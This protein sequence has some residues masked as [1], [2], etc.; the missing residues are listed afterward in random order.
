MK[1][2]FL[3]ILTIFIGFF[4]KREDFTLLLVTYGG[5]FAVYF[6]VM[7]F[8]LNDKGLF[9]KLI[10]LG[11]FL[12]ICLLFNIPNLSDD[13]Y[14]FLWDGRL[15]MQG[16]HPFLHQPAYF[17][18]HSL[19]AAGVTPDFVQKLNS[20]HYFTVYPPLCQ[21]LFSI[22]AWIFPTDEYW[23]V[24]LL[25]LFL[26]TC[27]IG[28]IYFL[29][30]VALK[31]LKNAPNAA[32]IYALNPLAIIEIVGNVHF[33]GAMLFF[34]VA[35]LW[36]FLENKLKT[37]ALLLSFSI[38]F[39]LLPLLFL[40]ILVVYLFQNKTDFDGNTL[41]KPLN[42]AKWQRIIPF[43]SVLGIS[44]FLQF[45]P[46]YNLEVIQN[47]GKSLDLYF[48]KFE[49]NASVYYLLRT[50]GFW[51]K[52][53]NIGYLLAPFLGVLTFS[54]V[55]ILS[56]WKTAKTPKKLIERLLF[57]SVIYLLF[58]STV[59]PWYVLV[60]MLLGSLTRFRFVMI[61]SGMAILSYSHYANGVF[62]EQYWWIVLEYL[63]V[64]GWFV[65]ENTNFA[66]LEK[67]GDALP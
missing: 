33:E 3:L 13:F 50:V 10:L 44:L 21:A 22:V 41:S 25:K 48:Q 30:K 67:L 14:R 59:H 66:R 42:I 61:W 28:T 53:Y 23:G 12:R 45:I 1:Y 40:P 9:P 62:L 16:I 32:L 38:T 19:T 36:Y 18:E 35:G 7:R 55:L 24:F 57:A 39:K 37:A 11:V 58:S 27:E 5:L 34:M 65:Y 49:F 56:F 60:P 43:L 54:S 17:L 15:T 4:L 46:F 29:Y 20:I 8:F 51:Y 64:L 52:G 26:L 31:H 47:M 63:V 2:I 6:W